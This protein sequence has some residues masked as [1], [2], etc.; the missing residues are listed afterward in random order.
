MI[1][2][3]EPWKEPTEIE[4]IPTDV[5]IHPDYDQDDSYARGDLGFVSNHRFYS[6]LNMITWNNRQLYCS[7]QKIY[8]NGQ[9]LQYQMGTYKIMIS[10]VQIHIQARMG[11]GSEWNL[12][13]SWLGYWEIWDIGIGE[14]TE[15]LV[16]M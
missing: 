8:L 3:L 2:F 1:N 16:E 11:S 7:H 15:R 4:I 10:S 12:P 5:F 14:W 6:F 13:F 9:L